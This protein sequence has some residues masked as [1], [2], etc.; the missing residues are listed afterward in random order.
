MNKL[1]TR[2]MMNEFSKLWFRVILR[3]SWWPIIL[4]IC[5]LQMDDEW[6]GQNAVSAHYLSIYLSV[7]LLR[8]W[9]IDFVFI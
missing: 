4:C 7:S 3:S 5:V 2:Q 1:P 6:Q 9:N 8:R